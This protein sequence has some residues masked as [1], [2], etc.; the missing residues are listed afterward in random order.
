MITQSAVV[1]AGTSCV[2]LCSGRPLACP[3][4]RYV[5][6]DDGAL[7]QQH[8]VVVVVVGLQT[9]VDV[10]PNTPFAL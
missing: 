7:A 8:L 5:P 2:L 1:Q 10:P 9:V 4:L 6:S 3:V